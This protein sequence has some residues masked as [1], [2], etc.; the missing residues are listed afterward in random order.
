MRKWSAG[1]YLGAWYNHKGAGN[2]SE[3]AGSQKCVDGLSA[4]EI[5]DDSPEKAIETELQWYLKSIC[6]ERRFSS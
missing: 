1:V 2:T 6:Y 5:A 3:Y 4:I